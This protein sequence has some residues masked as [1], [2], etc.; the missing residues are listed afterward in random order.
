VVPYL[1][2]AI[3]EVINEGWWAHIDR[4]DFQIA[5]GC[6]NPRLIR[7]GDKGGAV[8]RHTW[9]IA[10]DINPS[11][12][13]YGGPVR[14][15]ERIGEIFRDWGFAWGAGWRFVDGAHFEWTHEASS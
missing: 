2:S 9:G 14:M 8:S 10:I 12:N 7:G 3:D 5:G 4:Q 11:D 13:P 1:R 15:D 6:Y